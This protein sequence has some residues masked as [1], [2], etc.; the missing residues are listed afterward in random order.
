MK[1]RRG[2]VLAGIHL[3]IA[4]PLIVSGRMPQYPAEKTHS[5]HQIP[6]PGLKLAA[7]QEGE[8]KV[9]PVASCDG[10]R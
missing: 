4:V 8:Q 6:A 7:Y 10:R 2:L 3:A 5:S 9:E 1:W